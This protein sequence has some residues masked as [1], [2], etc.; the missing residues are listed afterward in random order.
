MIIS[1]TL[2]CP[3]CHY[4]VKPEPLLA[5]GG[6]SSKGN[7]RCENEHIETANFMYD[8]VQKANATEQ[9]RWHFIPTSQLNFF[10]R[11]SPDD[12]SETE[13]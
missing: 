2:R 7:V 12:P 11:F 8:F 3:T 10:I 13:L 9:L 1:S 5:A 6:C 4:P